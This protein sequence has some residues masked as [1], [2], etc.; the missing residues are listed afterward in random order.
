MGAV[1]GELRTET[2]QLVAAL[3]APQVRGRWGEHQ[4]RRIVE[5]AG[6]ARALRLRRAGHRGHRPPGRTPRPG[7]PAAR[8]PDGGGRREGAVRRVPVRDG[9]ARRAQPRRPPRR[10]T[11]GTCARTSTRWRPRRTGRR[12]TP[13]PEFVVLFVPAD[14]FL[15]AALQ[16]DPTLLEHAFARNVVLATP[17]TLVA[18]L[19]TVAYAWRQEALAR[20]AV[21]V[22]G[23]ARE[24][25]GRLSTLGDH[26]GK[27]GAVAGRRRSPR[28]TR[29]SARWRR[30]CWSAPASWPSWASPTTSWPTPAQVELDPAPAP[31]RRSWSTSRSPSPAPTVIAGPRNYSTTADNHREPPRGSA[32]KGRLPA[33]RSGAGQPGGLHVA[34]E[35]LRQREGQPLLGGGDLG[36]RRRSRAR[37]GAPSTSMTR[38]SGTLA[39]D[40]TPT[41]VGARPATRPGSRR[42]S[43]PGSRPGAGVQRD[44]DQADRVGG[45][46]RA[47]D[48]HHVAVGRDLL[49][50]VLPVLGGVADVVAG[51]RLQQRQPLS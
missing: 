2:K 34:A 22:H 8:R 19:R 13:T 30:G 31:G 42:R 12:S 27:L 44:L 37:P 16:R 15:D 32:P 25:Y 1:S 35:L 36:R 49:D 29:R 38:S 46:R 17:A 41:V 14:P 23:L 26:V 20:N 4:L 3:R 6:H 40:V 51:R 50:H 21:A 11:P 43:R 47:D 45:V 18:L 39:P 10:S 7:G 28:T 24:L 9:G 5:A 33:E 48:D